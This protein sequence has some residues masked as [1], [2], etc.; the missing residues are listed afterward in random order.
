MSIPI[1]ENP[2]TLPW[3]SDTC[4]YIKTVSSFY[5]FTLR[6][7]EFHKFTTYKGNYWLK[8]LIPHPSPVLKASYHITLPDLALDEPVGGIKSRALNMLRPYTQSEWWVLK[9]KIHSKKTVVW[10]MGPLRLG[11]LK[12][13]AKVRKLQRRT[14]FG[15]FR[16]DNRY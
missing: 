2:E 14:K 5:N 4:V 12:E 6:E 7:R 3:S 15:A 13:N 10:S 11:I 1:S 8:W 16:K 9:T